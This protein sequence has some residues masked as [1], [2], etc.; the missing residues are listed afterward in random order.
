MI[1]GCLL[2]LFLMP[3]GLSEPAETLPS[4]KVEVRMVEIY[5]A[6]M[7]GRKYVSGLQQGQFQVL[8]NGQLQKIVAF[9]AEESPLTMALLLDTTGSMQ[10]ALPFVKNAVMQLLISMRPEDK[11]GLFS[12]TDQLQ[13]LQPFGK[14]K[15]LAVKALLTTKAR[16]TTALFDALTQLSSAILK[17]KGKKAILVFTDGDDNSSALSESAAVNNLKR[18]GVPVY[19]VAQGNALSDSKLMKSIE[20]ITTSTGG[21][22]FEV[23]D[24]DELVKVFGEIGSDLQHLYFLSYYPESKIKKTSWQPITVRLAK[25]LHYKVRAKEGYKP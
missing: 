11:V 1:P 19:A 15:S 13:V 7:D 5:A 8:E 22:T 2:F 21:L 16:G 9:E 10:K 12:F 23:K 14:E 6:V 20:E 18:T 25:P 3:Q 24:T 4:L 17:V